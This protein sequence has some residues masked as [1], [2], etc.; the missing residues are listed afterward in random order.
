MTV[1]VTNPTLNHEREHE[2]FRR[3]R[4]KKNALFTIKRWKWGAWVDGDELR[5]KMVTNGDVIETC[6]TVTDTDG[7]ICNEDLFRKI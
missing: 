3:R 7:D 5:V 2:R 4:R 6:E 1:M